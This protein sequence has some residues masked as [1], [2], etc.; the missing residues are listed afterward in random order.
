MVGPKGLIKDLRE[1]YSLRVEMPEYAQKWVIPNDE[2]D[3]FVKNIP[4]KKIESW[5]ETQ[6]GWYKVGSKE[7]E[8]FMLKAKDNKKPQLLTEYD[9]GEPRELTEEELLLLELEKKPKKSDPQDAAWDY[10]P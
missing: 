7:Y 10:Q 1:K 4:N 8:E 3:E 9:G 5:L 2:L 6:D